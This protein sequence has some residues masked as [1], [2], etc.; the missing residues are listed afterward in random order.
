MWESSGML[1]RVVPGA[2]LGL[3]S[4]C[5]LA[6]LF[7]IFVQ[8][9]ISIFVQIKTVIQTCPTWTGLCDSAV[10]ETVKSSYGE[11]T[12]CNVGDGARN[13]ELLEEYGVTESSD[14]NWH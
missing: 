4:G 14:P 13:S 6:D 3:R 1:R 10:G 9:K 12:R 11:Y 8:N 5:V 2:V 7:S